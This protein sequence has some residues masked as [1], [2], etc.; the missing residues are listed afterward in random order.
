MERAR[1][2]GEVRE[3]IA[4]RSGAGAFALRAAALAVTLSLG[5]YLVFAAQRGARPAKAA[6]GGPAEEAPAAEVATTEVPGAAGDEITPEEAYLW[7]SKSG[8]IDA[9]ELAGGSEETSDELASEP[10]AGDGAGAPPTFLHGSKSL[11]L[12]PPSAAAGPGGDHD[13]KSAERRVFLPSSK[14]GAIAP[15]E[16]PA[17]E[18]EDGAAAP[19]AKAATG[20]SKP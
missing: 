7:S 16:P 17:K 3:S 12:E 14:F 4:Q 19:P 18:T 10:A 8:A 1:R 11:V 6:P 2:G 15:A 20:A 5:A 9:S 13:A